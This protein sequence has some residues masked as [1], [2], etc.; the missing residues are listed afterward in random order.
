MASEPRSR[1]IQISGPLDLRRTIGPLISPSP[2]L[3]SAGVGEAWKTWRTPDG[4]A[5]VRLEITAGGL[6]AEAWGDGAGWALDHVL[7]LAGGRDAPSSFQPDHPLLRDLQ[8]RSLGSRF[9]ATRSVFEAIVPSVLGQK[10]TTRE[11]HRGY[12]RLVERYGEPAPGPGN[13]LMA[14]SAEVLAELPYYEFHPLGI[15]RKRADIIRGLAARANR[16]EEAAHMD[17]EAAWR[18]LTAFDG[19]GPWTAALVMAVVHGD[20]DAVPVGDYHIPNTVAWALAGEPRGDDR[21]MLELLEP[22]RGHRGRVIRL[23]KHAKVRA[24]KYGPKST[25]RRFEH[26]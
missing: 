25:I 15:E 18:R 17:R 8:L 13:L 19:V 23:L 20:A 24:P 3:G 21:R 4:P 12:R 5:T 6:S 2:R 1:Y 22:Y 16:L 10:V 14:P 7:E 9:G 26:H 11:S